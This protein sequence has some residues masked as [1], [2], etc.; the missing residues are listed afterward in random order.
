MCTIERFVSVAMGGKVAWTIKPADVVKIGDDAFVKLKAY[1]YSL[2][3]LVAEGVVKVPKN[4]S[5]TNCPGLQ[6]LI[7]LRNET[8]AKSFTQPAAADAAAL[9]EAQEVQQPKR[10][11]QS[12]ADV[13]SMRGSPTVL[14][15]SMPLDGTVK[16]I[17]M[18]RP[19]H[20]CDELCIK[21]EPDV[22]EA[23]IRF[24]RGAGVTEDDLLNKRAYR[25]ADLP[26][27]VWTTKAGQYV[28]KLAAGSDCK[29]KRAKTA[30]QAIRIAAGAHCEPSAASH[31]EG[32]PSDLVQDGDS[33][34][35]TH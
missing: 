4:P 20:P 31:R 10:R 3:R 35:A 11:K 28:V 19:A 6:E 17:P 8:H 13:R 1:D 21:L 27:G 22:I 26:K 24:I 18:A 34:G 33:E 32:E 25:S 7:K 5:L 2:V 29:Y 16:D 9:F 15:I 23:V 12:V 30:Q 14:V